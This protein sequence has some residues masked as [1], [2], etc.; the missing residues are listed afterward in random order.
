MTEGGAQTWLDAQDSYWN[1]AKAAFRNR[2]QLDSRPPIELV[3]LID[4]FADTWRA[5]KNAETANETAQ[6][7]VNSLL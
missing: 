1:E 6:E 7:A 5:Q 4:D 2:F 3:R